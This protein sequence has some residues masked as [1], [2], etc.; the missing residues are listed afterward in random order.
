MKGADL[1]SL[2]LFEGVSDEALDRLAA[3]GQ[4]V[5]FVEGEVLFRQGEPAEVWWV[6]L[7]GRVELRRRAGHDESIVGA[8]ERPGVWAGGFLAWS[9]EAGYMVTGRSASA[10]R[11]F[12]VRAFF[13]N[14]TATT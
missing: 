3:A 2:F 12:C 6:L 5:S 8:M 7:E 1:R 4:E 10:G 11:M 14:D 13:F 9:G